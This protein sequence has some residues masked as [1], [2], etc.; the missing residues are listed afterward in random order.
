MD[1]A[2]LRRVPSMRTDGKKRSEDILDAAL[3]CF[4]KQGVVLTRIDDIRTQSGASPSSIYHLF[5]GMDAIL[6]ALLQRTFAR[7][8]Q[9]L[10]DRVTK[11]RT[12]QGAIKM[13]VTAHLDWVFAHRTEARVMYQA[14]SLEMTEQTATRLATCKAEMLTPV[15]THLARFIAQGDLP[16]WSPL[17]LDVVVLGASHEACRRYLAGA[18]LDAQWMRRTLPAL[19]WRSLTGATRPLARRRPAKRK[20]H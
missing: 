17:M 1:R 7:L 18:A 2:S 15:V 5:G 8:F 3:A 20:P 14:M 16:R 4:A 6:L 12:A 11:T 13:L 10:A 19:S 9:H